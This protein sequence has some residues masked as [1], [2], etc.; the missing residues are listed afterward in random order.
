MIT[1]NAI[2]KAEGVEVP[3]RF[4]I[5]VSQI[6]ELHHHYSDSLR[7]GNALFRLG[8][9]QGMKAAQAEMQKGKQYA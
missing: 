5:S 6:T 3:S 8:Y 7:F 2:K 4:S 9:M 1:K